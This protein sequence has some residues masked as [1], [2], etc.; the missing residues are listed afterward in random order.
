[1]KTQDNKSALQISKRDRLLPKPVDNKKTNRIIIIMSKQ[2]QQV[3]L[4]KSG[5]KL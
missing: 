1:V 2:G 5:F 3:M 4:E